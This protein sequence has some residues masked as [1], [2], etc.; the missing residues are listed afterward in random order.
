MKTIKKFLFLCLAM[1]FFAVANSQAQIVVRVR[2]VGPRVIVARP[3]RPSP[4]H[5]WVAPEYTTV[6]GAYVYQPGYWAVP[7]HPRAV[8]IAGRW[9]HSRRGYIWI[10]G[11]WA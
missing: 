1:S 9:R 2:P 3:M 6:N 7:P 4:R 10:A 5:V 8:W 11:R